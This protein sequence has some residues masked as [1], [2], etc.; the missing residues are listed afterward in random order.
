M[1]PGPAQRRAYSSGHFEL[2]IDDVVTPAYIK[3]VE[4]GFIK[5]NTADEP[6]GADNLRIKHLTTREVEPITLEVGMAQVNP[7]LNWIKA[8]WDRSPARHNGA[9][10]HVDFDYTPQFVHE[11]YQTLIEET[12]FPALDAASKDT[13]WMKVKL[14]PEW[15]EFPSAG[16]PK[17]KVDARARQKL[18]MASAFRLNVDG[19]DL[20]HVAKIDGFTV[21]QGIKPLTTGPTGFAE[22]EPTKIDFPDLK[23]TMSMAHA[24][25]VFDWYQQ[26]VVKG[27]KDTAA[28]RT[29]SIEFLS[30]DRKQTMLTINLQGVGIKSFSLG[31]SEANADQTKR[32]TFELYVSKMDLDSRDPRIFIE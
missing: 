20:R 7:L 17:I 31:K 30:P 12:S 14:R 3:S 23:V 4:G 18:W 26:V 21:K 24:G 5:M 32:C 8:S 22:L 13:L 15:V 27:E 10:T 29:G 9:I 11:F 25:A 2:R 19:L 28:E 6:A 16:G 1:L